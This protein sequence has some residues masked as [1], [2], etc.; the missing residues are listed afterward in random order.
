MIDTDLPP[1]LRDYAD[2][3]ATAAGMPLEDLRTA[4]EH[5]GDGAARALHAGW[6]QDVEDAR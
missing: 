2:H 5:G 6:A 1:D 4:A 3:L